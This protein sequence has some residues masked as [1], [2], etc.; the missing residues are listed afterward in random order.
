MAVRQFF[1]VAGRLSFRPRW[2]KAQR[3]EASQNSPFVG[4]SGG[5]EQGLEFQGGFALRQG[6]GALARVRGAGYRGWNAQS[7]PTRSEFTQL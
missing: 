2:T 3:E 5:I 4:E 1:P 6:A 7:T